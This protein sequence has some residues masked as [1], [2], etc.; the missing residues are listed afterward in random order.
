MERVDLDHAQREADSLKRFFER[1]GK[2]DLAEFAAM[3][4]A[5]V[6]ELTVARTQLGWVRTLLD[7]SP[8]GPTRADAVNTLF[9]IRQA[10]TDDQHDPPATHDQA[11][12]DFASSNEVHKSEPPERPC[13]PCQDGEHERCER[14]AMD[15]GAG[16]FD[17][18]CCDLLD[19]SEAIE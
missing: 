9:Q 13:R 2:Q 6:D 10:L 15:E 7:A 11:G 18:C 19:R 4:R 12:S 8:F 14:P 5:L 16:E 17:L 1:E 3:T